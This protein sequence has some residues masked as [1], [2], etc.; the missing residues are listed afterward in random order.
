MYLIKWEDKKGFVP[1]LTCAYKSFVAQSLS[2]FPHHCFPTKKVQYIHTCIAR[3]FRISSVT[4]SNASSPKS[5]AIIKLRYVNNMAV[6]VVHVATH[7]IN[8]ICMPTQ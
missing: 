2:R 4:S 5:G 3:E 1:G 8:Y 7:L 6:S